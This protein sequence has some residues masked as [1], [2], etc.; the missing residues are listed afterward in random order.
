LEAIVAFVAK[1]KNLTK[2]DLTN[3]EVTKAEDYQSKVMSAL[4]KN[5]VDPETRVILDGH[6]EDNIS[7]SD[8]SEDDDEMDEEGEMEMMDQEIFQ[9]MDPETKRKF[10]AGEISLEELEKMGILGFDDEYGEEGELELDEDED[11]EGGEKKA[12]Q[13]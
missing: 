5:Q 13:E 3:N 12:K 9:N 2:L 6:D 11:E 4:K 1:M 8:D 10:E 7:V